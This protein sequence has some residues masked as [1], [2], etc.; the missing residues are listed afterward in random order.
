MWHL[1]NHLLIVDD[2][3][4]KAESNPEKYIGSNWMERINS[5]K[6]RRILRYFIKYGDEISVYGFAT[7]SIAL[8]FIDNHIQYRQVE[9]VRGYSF[10]LVGDDKDVTIVDENGVPLV[11]ME[12]H[13]YKP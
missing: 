8:C 3:I 13:S 11:Y 12:D 2:E 4:R 10:R 9:W 6:N 5:W 1:A 7:R